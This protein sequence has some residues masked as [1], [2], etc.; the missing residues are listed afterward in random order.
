VAVLSFHRTVDADEPAGLSTSQIRFFRVKIR[1][2]GMSKIEKLLP[3]RL[4]NMQQL[5]YSLLAIG[6]EKSGGRFTG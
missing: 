4:Q 5:V 6:F 2:L 1:T 3:F